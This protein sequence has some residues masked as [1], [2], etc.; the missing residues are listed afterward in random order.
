[1]P[2]IL[3]GLAITELDDSEADIEDSYDEMRWTVSRAAVALLT[4][5]AKLLGDQILEDT[6]NFAGQKLNL[7]TWQD[8]YIGMMALGSIME[9]PTVGAL[10]NKLTPAYATIFQMWDQSPSSRVR[11]S[12]AFLISQITKYAPQLILNSPENLNLLM[13]NGLTHMRQDHIQV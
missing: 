3:D 8:H 4:E 7:Q 1:M 12:T 11:M 10:V 5:V 13:Q 9:G 6:I 2:I